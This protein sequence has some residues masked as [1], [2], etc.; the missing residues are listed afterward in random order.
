MSQPNDP[1]QEIKTLLRLI[2]PQV[3]DVELVPLASVEKAE[4]LFFW[5]TIFLTAWGTVFGTYLSLVVISFGNQPVI[6]LLLVALIFLSVLVLV[7]SFTGFRARTNARK[8]VSPQVQAIGEA[9]PVVQMDRINRTLLALL[10]DEFTREEF[11][12]VVDPFDDEPR[13][14]AVAQL[15]LNRLLV[16]KLVSTVDPEVNPDTF[17]KQVT[18]TVQPA[19]TD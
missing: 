6:L 11:V 10:P 8:Q 4:F 18:A 16:S 19:L 2:A 1:R 12:A 14:G 17:R 3:V 13:D 15:L 7:F 9:S 5:T